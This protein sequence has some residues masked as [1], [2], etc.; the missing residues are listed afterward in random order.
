MATSSGNNL[1]SALGGSLII[2]AISVMVGGAYSWAFQSGDH[3]VRLRIDSAGNQ[4]VVLG[5][6]G[7]DEPIDNAPRVLGYEIST[8]DAYALWNEGI[9]FFLD[10]RSLEEYEQGHIAYSRY[11]D[12]EHLYD[13]PFPPIVNELYEDPSQPI[14]FYCS[15]GEC[16]ASHNAATYFQGLGFTTVHVYMDGYPGWVEAGY[17]TEAGPDPLMEQP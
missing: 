11:L 17:E 15:G 10:A 16:D 6:R 14:V 4:G 5:A 9:V 13:V 1:A 12:Y 8:E 2:V 3:P 7:G